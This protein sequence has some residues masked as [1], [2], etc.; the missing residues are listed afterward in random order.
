MP[1]VIVGLR[2]LYYALLTA[3][4]VGN[5]TYAPPVRIVGAIQASITPNA[6]SDTLFADDGPMEVAS[7][8]GKID[9][10][11]NASDFPAAAQVA[12][13]G[14]SMVAGVLTRKAGDVAPWV[15]IGFQAPKSNGADRF[16][17][18]AKGKF[19][20]PD[21]KHETKNDKVNFQTPTLKGSFTRRDGDDVWIKQVDT[22]DAD[23]MASTGTNWFLDVMG[24][25]GVVDVI[26]PTVTC[27]PADGA[28]AVSVAADIVFTF[29]EGLRVSTITA[30]NFIVMDAAGIA[31]AGTLTPSVGDT[32]VTFNPTVNL[33]AATAYIAL[34][35]T[36]VRDANGNA[37]A[38]TNIFNF[39]TA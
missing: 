37:L 8:L 6:S 29:S 7:V 27:V 38:A 36:N 26:A 28:V 22:D 33:T 16:V 15:A 3:D 10:E 20:V 34:V 1:G 19:M 5:I 30:A 21:M 4:A 17:W 12:L 23:Y 14:H 35:T 31:V 13:L 32:V 24:A 11:A 2:N 25:A 39:T 18:L 9:M